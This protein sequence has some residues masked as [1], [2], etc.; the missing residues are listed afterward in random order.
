ME[1]SIKVGIAEYAASYGT[2]TIAGPLGDDVAGRLTLT[3]RKTDGFLRN[4]YLQDDVVNDFQENAVSA[5]IVFDPTD[6][7]SIDTKI[8]FSSLNASIVSMQPL[9]YRSS[10]G[11]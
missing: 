4:D 8:R 11:L 9:N 3:T 1:G 5:R 6:T 10:L 7:L 2:A